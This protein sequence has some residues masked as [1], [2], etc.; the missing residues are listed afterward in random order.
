MLPATKIVLCTL[1]FTFTCFKKT[2]ILPFISFIFTFFRRVTLQQSWFS[3]VTL[4]SIFLTFPEIEPEFFLTS[5]EI[6]CCILTFKCLVK[7]FK[8]S[9]DAIL[10]FDKQKHLI[11]EIVPRDFHK[12]LFSFWPFEPHFLMNVY[13]KINV[14]LALFLQLSNKSTIN[15]IVDFLAVQ[16]RYNLLYS[17]QLLTISLFLLRRDNHLPCCYFLKCKVLKQLLQLCTGQYL[18]ESWIRQKNCLEKLRFTRACY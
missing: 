6:N 13:L 7:N 2:V 10:I 18:L 8:C 3:R 15:W 12:I 1:G 16:S 9:N 11:L 5:A 17:D 4:A 14:C